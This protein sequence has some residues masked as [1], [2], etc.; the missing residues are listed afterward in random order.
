MLVNVGLFARQ[1]TTQ[2]VL[3]MEDA[4]QEKAGGREISV[5]SSQFCYKPKTVKKKG[6]GLPGTCV[7]LREYSH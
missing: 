2:G 4:M 3:T 6:G 5:T 1:I 7:K